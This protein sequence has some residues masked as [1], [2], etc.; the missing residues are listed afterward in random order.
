MEEK[1]LNSLPKQLLLVKPV[2]GW[3]A[4]VDWKHRE[5]F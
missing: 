4:A 5:Y 3:T 1:G 2:E